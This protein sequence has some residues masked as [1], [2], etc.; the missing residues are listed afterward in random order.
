M[1]FQE[2]ANALLDRSNARIVCNI[3]LVAPKDEKLVM[4]RFNKLKEDFG[5]DVRGEVKLI[6]LDWEKNDSKEKVAEK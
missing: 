2:K 3:K 4:D 5:I 6:P 1:K